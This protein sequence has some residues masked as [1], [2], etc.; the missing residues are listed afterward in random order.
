V[1]PLWGFVNQKVC[2]SPSFPRAAEQSSFLFCR[3]EMVEALLAAGHLFLMA[4]AKARTSSP[5]S[6]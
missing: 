4:K 5:M 2:R 1:V 3:S 6:L